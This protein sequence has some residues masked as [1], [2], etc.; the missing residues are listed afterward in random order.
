MELSAIPGVGEK[1]ADALGALTG[2]P[3]VNYAACI[4]GREHGCR[5]VLRV[6]EDEELQG[7]DISEHGMESYGGFQIFSNM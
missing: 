1:T 7:L 3:T 2:D 5:T 4:V 6:S